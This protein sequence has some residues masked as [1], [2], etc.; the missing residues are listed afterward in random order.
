MENKKYHFKTIW[1]SDLHLGTNSCQS[2]KLLGF[3]KIVSCDNLFLVGDIID[4]WA[5]HN[6][7]KWT[8]NHN[9]IIQKFLKKARYGTNIVYIPGNHDDAIRDYCGMVFGDIKVERD[10]IY[11]LISGKK[12]FITHGDDYDIV[13][14]YHKWLAKLGDVSYSVLLRLNRW[15]LYIMRVCG[16]NSRFSL[17]QFIKYKVKEAVNFISD[18]EETVVNSIKHMNI[19]GVIT[20]HIHHPEIR[21]IDGIDYYNCGDGVESCSALV[22]TTTGEIKI[23]KWDELC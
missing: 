9:T 3:L 2:D 4:F 11:T 8:V 5:L 15:F 13:T 10:Y 20:G 17:S 19:D 6:G 23:V 22:E 1:L 14:K 21:Q 16:Y 7:S 12:V 18:Y